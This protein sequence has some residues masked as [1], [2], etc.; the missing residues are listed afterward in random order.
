MKLPKVILLLLF[1][2]IQTLFAQSKI[3]RVEPPNWWVDMKNAELQLL[4]YGKNIGDLNPS[5]NYQGV[6]IQQVRKV[7]NPN[8]LF[9]DLVIDETARPGN[10]PITF[11]HHDEIVATHTYELFPREKGAADIQGFDNKDVMYLITPD[12]FVNGDPKMTK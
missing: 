8:Y 2:S 5:I 11:K 7:E 3:E 4:V 12:R 10:F 1:F 6:E 9:L